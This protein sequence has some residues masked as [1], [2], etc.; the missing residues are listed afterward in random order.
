MDVLKHLKL[1]VFFT[2][3]ISLQIWDQVGMLE[4]E[5][6]LYRQLLPHL[7]GITFLTYGDRSELQYASCLNGIE[8]LCNHWG[9]PQ[10]LYTRLLPILH[11]RHLLRKDN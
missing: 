9:L 11:W 8:I 3:G 4:R 10:Q 1:V 6:A 5:V 2:R 7:K